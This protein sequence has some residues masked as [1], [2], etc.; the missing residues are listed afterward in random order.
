MTL[1][2][3]VQRDVELVNSRVPK[4][5]GPLGCEHS[6]VSDERGIL[7]AHRAVHSGND[8]FQVSA[9]GGL[10]SGVSDHH[11]IEELRCVNEA[12]ELS[13]ARARLGLPIVAKSASRVAA[14]SDFKM[15]ED[16][17][18]DCGEIGVLRKENRHMPWLELAGKHLGVYL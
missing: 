9:K 16:W 1:I 10:A 17:F 14:K 2:E 8:V 7:N 4:R 3:E 11:R 18:P 5:L 15:D 12:G 13:C 6:A